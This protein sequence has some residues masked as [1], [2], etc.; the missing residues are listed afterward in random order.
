MRQDLFICNLKRYLVLPFFDVIIIELYKNGYAQL[1][2]LHYQTISINEHES[3]H[4]SYSSMLFVLL[5]VD[6]FSPLVLL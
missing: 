3:N 2:L 6:P 4:N 5:T 1:F